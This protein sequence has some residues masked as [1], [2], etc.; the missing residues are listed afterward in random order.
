MELS[1]YSHNRN[2]EIRLKRNVIITI[3]PGRSTW[4]LVSFFVFS[5]FV[6]YFCGGCKMRGELDRRDSSKGEAN[7]THKKNPVDLSL[8]FYPKWIHRQL[9]HCSIRSVVKISPMKKCKHSHSHR[10]QCSQK[11]YTKYTSQPIRSK[12]IRRFIVLAPRNDANAI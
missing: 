2:K 3:F 12:R 1:V 9:W 6:F 11:T 7:E 4:A 5:S 8:W 10:S